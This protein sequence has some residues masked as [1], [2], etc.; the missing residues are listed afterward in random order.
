MSS[1]S[2]NV[3]LSDIDKERFGIQTARVV[4]VTIESLPSILEFC[5]KEQVK[6]LIARCSMSDLK[7]AQTMEKKG[8]LLMDTLVYYTLDLTKRKI[9]SD[10]GTA[11]FRP[12]RAGEEEEMVS[13]ATESFRGYFGHYHA[14]PRLDNNKCDEAYV[15]WARKAC[16]S[17]GSDE[18]FLVAEID[19]RIVAFGVFRINSPDEGELFLGGIHPDFQGQGIYL[20]FLCRAMEW[21]LSKNTRRIVISTQLN[22]I[23]VQKVLTRF[24]FEISRGYYTYHKWFD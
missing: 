7:I 1:A 8:F 24:G 6:L 13:V 19:G 3:F 15:D 22:N 9:P 23:A 16:A 17:R 21:C 5:R 14:D 2:S 20:S 11:H 12:I 18:N 10:N 4:G